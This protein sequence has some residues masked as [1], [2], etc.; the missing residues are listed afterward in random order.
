MQRETT[1]PADES[2]FMSEEPP[3][4]FSAQGA[5][6]PRD[7]F[8]STGSRRFPS[9]SSLPHSTCRVQSPKKYAN[10]PPTPKKEAEINLED[11]IDLESLRRFLATGCHFF[12]WV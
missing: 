9:F 3:A 2:S 11:D 10:A 1:A 5:D 4:Q 7:D 12:L 8:G 6:I